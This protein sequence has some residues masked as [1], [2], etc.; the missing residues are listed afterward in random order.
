MI[1]G[2][3]NMLQLNDVWQFNLETGFWAEK[4]QFPSLDPENQTVVEGL[5]V[6]FLKMPTAAAFAATSSQQQ[7]RIYVHGGYGKQLDMR[8]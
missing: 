5:P 4:T 7:E 1:G 3:V 2:S 8:R 6:T